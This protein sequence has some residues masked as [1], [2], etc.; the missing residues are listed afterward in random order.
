MWMFKIFLS[1]KLSLKLYTDLN[2]HWL[3]FHHIPPHSTTHRH[4]LIFLLTSTGAHG[5]EVL[6]IEARGS[7]GPESAGDI[8][9]GAAEGCGCGEWGRENDTS[10]FP[11]YL[12]FDMD[13]YAVVIVLQFTK[14]FCSLKNIKNIEMYLL[15][16]VKCYQKACFQVWLLWNTMKNEQLI[17]IHKHAVHKVHPHRSNEHFKSRLHNLTE[18]WSI[19]ERLTN[20]SRGIKIALQITQRYDF[21]LLLRKLLCF[22]ALHVTKLWFT[23]QTHTARLLFWSPCAL[24]K[25]FLCRGITPGC[26]N[27]SHMEPH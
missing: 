9:G 11:L 10:P 4:T 17:D 26:P 5:Q 20:V 24:L 23:T 15:Q 27:Y 19:I 7:A 1:I 6:G 8:L 18:P 2:L 16:R 25:E 21:Y 12:F 3:V 14:W 22:W 13:L